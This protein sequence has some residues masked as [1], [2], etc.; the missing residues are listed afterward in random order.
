MQGRVRFA[1]REGTRR[2]GE[3]PSVRQRAI[4]PTPTTAG[5][6]SQS[7]DA[8]YPPAPSQPPASWQCLAQPQTA[9]LLDGFCPEPLQEEEVALNCDGL[10]FFAR[11]VDI[12]WV[13]AAGDGVEIRVGPEIHWLRETLCGMAAKL[14]PD[15]F[16]R[17]SPSML[18]NRDL[19]K[20]SRSN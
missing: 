13:Q 3:P 12:E 18:V 2:A 6:A 11:L 17:L 10:I 15:R 14:P 4:A 5:E 16:L 1:W 20:P 7:V 19:L 9:G 8:S